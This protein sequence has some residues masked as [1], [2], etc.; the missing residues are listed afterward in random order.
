MQ[1][2]DQK[3]AFSC[4]RQERA[5]KRHNRPTNVWDLPMITRLLPFYTM[6]IPLLNRI[7]EFEFEVV[8][9]TIV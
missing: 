5:E 8:V 4:Q 3:V 2:G 7:Q 6:T 9:M 1:Q